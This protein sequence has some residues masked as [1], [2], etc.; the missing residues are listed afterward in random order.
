MKL[1]EEFDRLVEAPGAMPRLRRFI[2]DWLRGGSSL[3]RIRIRSLRGS[4]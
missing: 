1:L 2:L 3:S 4:C